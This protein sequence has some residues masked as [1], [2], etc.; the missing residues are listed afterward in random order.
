MRR[1]LAFLCVLIGPAAGLWIAAQAPIHIVIM[2]TNDLHGQLLPRNGAGGIAEIAT[3][4]R[5]AKPDL[6]LDAG[7]ISTGT[8]LS[9]EFLGE[10]TIQAMSKIGYTSGTIGNHEFDYGQAALRLLLQHAG[11]PFLAANVESPIPEIKKYTIATVQGIRF[12]IIGLTTEALKTQTH[13]KNVGGVTVLDFV[14]TLEQLLPEVREKSD[15][16]IA[17]VH[18]ED[19]ED[20]RLASAFPE[21]RLVI[22]GHNHSAAGPTWIGQTLVAK[23]GSIGRNLGRVDLDFTAK[24]LV[25]MEA[26]LIPV[27]DVPADP[28]IRNVLR[29]FNDHVREKMGQ[30]LGE[31][32][33]DLVSSRSTESPLADLI[34]DAFRERSGAQIALHNIGGIRANISKGLITWGAV[35][36]VLP[37]QNTMVRLKMTGAQL[38]KILEGPELFALSGVRVRFNRNRPRGQQLVSITL[39]DGTPLEDSRLYSL[40]TND[41]LVAGGDG[42]TEF[43]NGTD[44]ED[45]GFFLRDA[46]VD[47]VKRH[48]ILSPRTD[49][50]I[51]VGN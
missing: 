24:K 30:V 1:T 18:L 14:K 50:R 49:G 35:F 8:F 12:G 51:I 15:F 37:F 7:D 13:P 9:D 41:F 32:S 2:H 27:K 19:A 45:T 33:A 44:I 5:R 25:R 46:V 43:A 28:E 4:V 31:A 26:R 40:V 16:I 23:T 3:I 10:P 38:R 20:A 22:G 47:Y 34:A 36:E 21:I 29:P 17:T 39:L 48:P 42:I 11:F 6:M